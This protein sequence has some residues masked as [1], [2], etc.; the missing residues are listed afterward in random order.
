MKIQRG[1]KSSYW[2]IVLVIL[3]AFIVPDVSVYAS[4]MG[5]L[6]VKKFSVE[7]YENLKEATGQASDSANV[8]TDAKTIADVAFSIEKLVVGV[9]DTTV[10]ISNPVDPSFTKLRQTTDANGETTFTNLPEGYYLVTEEIPG[11]FD[12]LDMGKFIVKIPMEITDGQGNKSDLYDVT[13]FPKNRT[14][15]VEKVLNDKKIVV[16]VDDTPSWTVKYPVGSDL[17]G[18]KN[19]FITDHMDTRLDYVDGSAKLRYLD[20]NGKEIT[21]LKL[22]EGVDYSITYD[23]KTHTLT[24]AY[25]D[26]VGTEKVADAGV[27]TIELTLTTKV[28]EGAIK[29]TTP[30]TNNAKISYV[31]AIGDPYEHEVFP[32]GTNPEDSRVP[33]VYVGEIEITKVS[34]EDSTQ[35]LAG[36]EFA[37]ASSEDNAKAGKFISRKVNGK[38]E[39]IQATTDANGKASITAIAAGTYYLV[40]TNAPAGF[41]LLSEPIKVTIGNDKDT[42]KAILEI[43]NTPDGSNPSITPANPTSKPVNP[44]ATPKGGTSGAKTGDTTQIMG[45]I[46]LIAASLGIIGFVVKRRKSKSSTR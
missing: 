6:T 9:V 23:A 28:N 27:V 29:D 43:K 32:P 24:I 25:T 12:A 20:R 31:N 35:V 41:K 10:N 42:K 3:L 37:L 2:I 36:A 38:Q 44:T 16:G 33:K 18:A 46:L 13:F 5:S 11:G 4:Q 14:I 39:V 7:N 22:A 40:E 21:S 30:I 26:G 1:N 19:F 8:P 45:Y 15:K 34:Q 17:K